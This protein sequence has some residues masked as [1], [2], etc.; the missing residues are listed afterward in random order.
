[1]RDFAI[2]MYVFGFYIGA[3]VVALAGGTYL[4]MKLDSA[5]RKAFNLDDEGRRKP[6][7]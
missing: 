5:V 1:V 4:L 3:A 6:K 7:Q 2:D